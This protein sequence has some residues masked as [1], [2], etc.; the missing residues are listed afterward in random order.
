MGP[1]VH[2]TFPFPLPDL[3][4]V[5]S[6]TASSHPDSPTQPVRGDTKSPVQCS[7]SSWSAHT[8]FPTSVL[9][10]GRSIPLAPNAQLPPPVQLFLLPASAW[11][12]LLGKRILAHS[13]HFWVSTR[14]SRHTP[15]ITLYHNFLFSASSPPSPVGDT[16]QESELC[17]SSEHMVQ[18]AHVC[19]TELTTS[20]IFNQSCSCYYCD[21]WGG[22]VKLQR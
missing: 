22:V 5:T 8:P 4:P 9:P 14:C 19:S 7:H 10:H 3:A 2:P 18:L 17:V 11:H 16:G 21:K 6:L 20:K 13:G 12:F 15:Q 1:F